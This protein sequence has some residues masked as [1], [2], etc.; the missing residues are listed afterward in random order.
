[1]PV[2][3]RQPGHKS[4][5]RGVVIAIA[6]VTA[7][8]ALVVLW[9]ED[10]PR[11][12]PSEADPRL[13]RSQ[14][15]SPPEPQSGVHEPPRASSEPAPVEPSEEPA[16][17]RASPEPS[18]DLA[19]TLAQHMAEVRGGRTITGNLAALLATDPARSVA[20]LELY[21]QDASAEVRSRAY[22]LLAE[23]ARLTQSATV[24][25]ESVA[26]L[27][28]ALED[29][30]SLVWQH[31]AKDLLT[32]GE[33]DFTDASR[34]TI[35][36]HL[37][38]PEPRREEVRIAGVAGL[39]SEAE[40]LEGL[41]NE[42]PHH[43]TVEKTVNYYGTVEW[44]AILALARLGSDAA[45][46][47][48]IERVEAETNDVIRVGFLLQDLAYTRQPAAIAVIR[49]YLES[50][51]RL[52]SVKPPH[53]GKRF[54]QHALDVLAETINGFP[55]QKRNPGAYSEQEIEIAAD[56]LATPDNWIDALVD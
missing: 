6:A 12:S 38:R 25:R 4:R 37:L 35:R 11:E 31:A 45:L 2:V 3:R 20:L 39:Q 48:A 15:A 50:R 9:N 10:R 40:R 22:A 49:E 24:R 41:A 43:P 51:D 55:V 30:A 29:P 46:A 44:A 56:W 14:A 32:F 7:A 42:A 21:I 54:S 36:R 8:G 5:L 52:P 16:D 47:R 1:M 19:S 18:E 26:H 13:S 33:G 27:V 23:L 34:D 28:R 53:P 17:E